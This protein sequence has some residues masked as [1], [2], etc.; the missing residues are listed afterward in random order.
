MHKRTLL[1]KGSLLHEGSLFYR[2]SFMYKVKKNRLKNLVEN[3]E[4]KWLLKKS[5]RPMVRV[6]GNSDSK[7][8]TIKKNINI[9]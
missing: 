5:Y 6:R 7:N 1:H 3:S 4:K 9:N 2:G 8:K